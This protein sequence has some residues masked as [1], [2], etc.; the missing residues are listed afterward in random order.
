MKDHCDRL[1]LGKNRCTRR[2][3]LRGMAGAAA[4]GAV[5]PLAGRSWAAELRGTDQ[6]VGLPLVL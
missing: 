4:L 3:V 1:G 2:T 6:P 5:W